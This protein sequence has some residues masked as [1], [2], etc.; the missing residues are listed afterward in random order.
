MVPLLFF[1]VTLAF[2]FL[3]HI[4]YHSAFLHA[5]PPLWN[6]LSQLCLSSECFSTFGF[7]FSHYL[8]LSWLGYYPHYMLSYLHEVFCC[9]IYH[10]CTFHD[11]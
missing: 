7:H 3:K 5:V 2:Q 1:L 4:S 11:F 10:C 6:A 9:S 8:V